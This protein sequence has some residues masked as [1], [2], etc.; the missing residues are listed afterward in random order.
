MEKQEEIWKDIKGYEGLYQV[1]NYGR[2][3]SLERYIEWKNGIR[4]VR[5]KILKPTENEN[6]YLRINLSKNDKP[7][8][9]KVHRLVAEAFIPNSEN[10]PCIDH[11]NTIRTDNRVENLRWVTYSENN[12]NPISLEKFIKS[13]KGKNQ[14]ESSILKKSKPV[15]QI[16]KNTGKIINLFSS[17][18]E[19]ERQLDFNQGNISS[20][21]LGKQKTAYGYYWCYT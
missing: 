4:L 14:P 2:I 11:I 7:K 21:C 3:K 19:V 17:S 6:K 10:K 12:L 8:T 15:L 9:I 13:K 20:C 5:E 18:K 1:S 16:D